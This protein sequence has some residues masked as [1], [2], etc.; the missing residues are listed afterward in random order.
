[1]RDVAVA[2]CS[3]LLGVLTDSKR[4]LRGAISK[5]AS[6]SGARTS[7]KFMVILVAV[8][9]PC[10]LIFF[11]TGLRATS[12]IITVNTL[13]DAST[14]GDGLCTLR[15]AINNANSASD[16]TGGDCAAGTGTDIITFSVS[17]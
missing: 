1:M 6:F 16:T 10:S 13:S 15:E 11:P 14:S 7:L 2:V 4:A 3:L 8:L 12:N 9:L 5:L 17:G